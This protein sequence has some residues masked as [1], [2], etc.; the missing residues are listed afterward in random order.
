VACLEGVSPFDFKEV[1]VYDGG[2]NLADNPEHR[3]YTAGVL[4][5]TPAD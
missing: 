4:T 2:R 5:F 1:L 3:T